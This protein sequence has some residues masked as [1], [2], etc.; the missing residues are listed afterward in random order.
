MPQNLNF[1]G[2]HY[3]HDTVSTIHQES[4]VDGTTQMARYIEVLHKEN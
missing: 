2:N 4:D 1:Y 3:T